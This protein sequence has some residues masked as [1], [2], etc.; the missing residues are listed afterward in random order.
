MIR[1][2]LNLT[3]SLLP[4]V[5]MMRYMKWK[6]LVRRIFVRTGMILN[7]H[8][9][10]FKRNMTEAM[11]YLTASVNMN[12]GQLVTDSGSIMR[13]LLL[14]PYALTTFGAEKIMTDGGRKIAAVRRKTT[15]ADMKKNVGAGRKKNTAAADKQMR[16]IT[17]SFGKE[18]VDR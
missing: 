5:P 18:T 9:S 3:E 8:K 17:H 1:K 2:R 12:A 14:K 10:C 13:T 6:R 16:N 7:M 11:R 15:S 4:C